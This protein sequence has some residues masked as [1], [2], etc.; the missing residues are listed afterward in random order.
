MG[1]SPDY[2]LRA[3]EQP[4][5]TRA[6]QAMA[7]RDSEQKGWKT[8][9]RCLLVIGTGSGHSP[10]PKCAISC[11]VKKANVQGAAF[12]RELAVSPMPPARGSLVFPEAATQRV[13]EVSN[14][15]WSVRSNRETL[16]LE[17]SCLLI[18]VTKPQGQGV[19]QCPAWH[20]GRSRTIGHQ[21]F[22]RQEES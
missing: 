13:T 9:E 16:A 18:S 15:R 22:P 4:K 10:H 6:W 8:R 7:E 14:D 3:K 2:R 11:S 19:R 20:D 21:C 12:P 5:H 1:R 17:T